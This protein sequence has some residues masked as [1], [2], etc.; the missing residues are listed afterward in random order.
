MGRSGCRI[1]TV[2]PFTKSWRS[3]VIGTNLY[4]LICGYCCFWEFKISI[5]FALKLPHPVL[6]DKLLSTRYETPILNSA[7]ALRFL[8]AKLTVHSTPIFLHDFLAHQFCSGVPSR[9]KFKAKKTGFLEYIIPMSDVL[10]WW[11]QFYMKIS[12]MW[13]VYWSE[14]ATLQHPLIFMTMLRLIE[15]TVWVQHRSKRNFAYLSR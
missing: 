5:V 7:L 6:M 12:T 3:S 14:D 8:S 11:A 1:L 15:V 4:V 10:C 13:T 2:A 9:Q